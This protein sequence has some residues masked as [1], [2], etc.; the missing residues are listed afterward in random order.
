M[1]R[2]Y[3][4][5]IYAGI[6]VL[7]VAMVLDIGYAKAAPASEKPIILKFSI[8]KASDWE[9]RGIWEVWAKRVKERTEGRVDIKFFYASALGQM[10]DQYDLLL[11]GIAD[12]IFLPLSTNLGIFPLSQIM[13]LPYVVPDMKK[14]TM[15]FNELYKTGCLDKEFANVKILWLYTADP[16]AIYSK[17]KIETLKDIKGKQI[18]TY[19]IMGT[20]MEAW[21]ATPVW[22]PMPDIYTALER[23]TV[24]GIYFTF[25]VGVG[26]KLHE[27]AKY[28]FD[29]KAHVPA[30]GMLMNK[31][32]WNNLPIDVKKVF[33]E[34]CDKAIDLCGEVYDKAYGDVLNTLRKYKV[35]LI[36]PK[37]TGLW[38]EATKQ[39]WV[40]WLAA[41][42][43]EGL[44]AEKVLDELLAIL[45]KHGL[46]GPP[47][48]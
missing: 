18:R 27:V 28:V 9:S 41:K 46:E 21:G 23:G 47:A 26:S 17:F 12:I 6:V 19:G 43:K 4:K 7:L 10:K 31:N 48:P 24:D 1:K 11:K 44:P 35:E 42:K 40:S 5:L 32:C 16:Y 3:H 14:G 45:R 36:F 8:F 22:I 20:T 38:R 25:S 33:T 2:G 30:L 15:V 29:P 37:E 34:E 13:E 39:Q